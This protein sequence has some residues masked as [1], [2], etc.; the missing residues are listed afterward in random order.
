MT[1]DWSKDKEDLMTELVGG[2][3][4][5]T[6]P[7]GLKWN[8]HW[9]EA[10]GFCWLTNGLFENHGAMVTYAFHLSLFMKRLN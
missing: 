5:G 1:T 7:I 8:E 9:F 4:L 2:I 6:K 10:Y 3:C